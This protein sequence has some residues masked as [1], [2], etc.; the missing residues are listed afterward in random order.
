MCGTISDSG[1]YWHGSFDGDN[2][3]MD[4]GREFDEIIESRKIQICIPTL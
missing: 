1:L 4:E 3:D 2:R